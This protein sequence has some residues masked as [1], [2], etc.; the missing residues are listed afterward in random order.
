M[1]A[2][3]YLLGILCAITAYGRIYEH[4]APD[5]TVTFTDTPNHNRKVELGETSSFQSRQPKTPP[6]NDKAK[7]HK[8]N[9][10]EDEFPLEGVSY[11]STFYISNPE[12]GENFHNEPV[13]TVN[14]I[15]TPKLHHQDQIQLLLD[16][17]PYAR[18][19]SAN[20]SLVNIQRGEH[21]LLAQIVNSAGRIVQSTVPFTIYVHRHS[22][23]HPTPR[24]I[25]PILKPITPPTPL[26]PSSSL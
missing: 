10:L 22:R 1:K 3:I 19:A 4:I 9:L 23:L 5:K 14:I 26:K 18:Q 16:G 15:M 20:F 11:Y 25:Q 8:N 7:P 21:Q 13:I 2:L 12:K 6:S 17:E 24:L